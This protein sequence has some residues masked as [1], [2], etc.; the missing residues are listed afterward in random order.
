MVADTAV[1]FVNRINFEYHQKPY[2]L[3]VISGDLYHN[4]LYVY[5]KRVIFSYKYLCLS[6]TKLNYIFF[7]QHH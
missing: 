2:K 7:S 4:I 1:K 5:K 3:N 6:Q